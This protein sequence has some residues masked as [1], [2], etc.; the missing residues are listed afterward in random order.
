MNEA[1]R[2][3]AKGVGEGEEEALL[4]GG[5]ELQDGEVVVPD[6][7]SANK[8]PGEAEGGGFQYGHWTE[9]DLVDGVIF[10]L[11]LT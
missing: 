4:Y 10:R 6:L 11:F 3:D 7:D 8:N 2:S 5:E 1:K 9:E